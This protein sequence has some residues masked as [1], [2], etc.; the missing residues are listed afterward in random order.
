MKRYAIF[1]A[2][3]F[4]REVMP[5]ARQQIHQTVREQIELVFVDDKPPASEVNG[6]RVLT[7]TQWISESAASRHI[8]IAVANSVVRQRLAERC[9][10]DGVTFFNVQ[11]PNVVVMDDVQM[12]EGSVLSPFVTLTSN[13]R[14]G[15]HFHANIY[16]YVAHDCVIGD[17][18]TLAPAVQCNGN[19]V[20]ED[21]AYIGTGA[22]LRQGTSAGEPLVIGR[23]AV[24]GMGAVVTKSVPEGAT[25]VGNPA[26]MMDPRAK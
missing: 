18:V 5:I 14:I 19:V 23:G 16:S 7:Y 1:G 10:S 9:Q 2:S 22:T 17:Y 24:V 11:A 6:H 26:R 25:V 3:G 21:H 12:G 4:G 20:I 15:K 8:C 13:I